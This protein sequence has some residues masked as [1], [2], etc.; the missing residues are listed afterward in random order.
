MDTRK[1]MKNATYPR[2]YFVDIEP[3]RGI[4]VI[5]VESLQL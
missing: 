4:E 3:M 5:D 2:A 1:F